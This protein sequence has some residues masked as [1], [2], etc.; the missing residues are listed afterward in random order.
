MARDLRRRVIHNVIYGVFTTGKIDTN[1]HV[2]SEVDTTDFR[3][4]GLKGPCVLN[5]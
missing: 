3:F 1:L 5:T 4:T 2:E